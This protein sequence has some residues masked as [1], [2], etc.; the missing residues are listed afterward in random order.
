MIHT[1]VIVRFS[2][3]GE[4]FKLRGNRYY[5]IY[6][7]CFGS[8]SKPISQSLAN[9]IMATYKPGQYQPNSRYS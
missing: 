8:K 9:Y 4:E 2:R 3:F 6:F 7:L 5:N 1:Q